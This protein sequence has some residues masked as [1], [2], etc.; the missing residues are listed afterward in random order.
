MDKIILSL[1]KIITNIF[2]VKKSYLYRIVKLDFV[3]PTIK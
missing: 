3:L 1:L 2:E